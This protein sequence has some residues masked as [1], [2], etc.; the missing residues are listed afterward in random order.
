M[1]PNRPTSAEEGTICRC[2]Q[3]RL[4][5]V[6][7]P[8]EDLDKEPATGHHLTDGDRPWQSKTPDVIGRLEDLEDAFDALYD[9]QVPSFLI[10]YAFRYALGRTS[11]AVGEVV[12]YL[13]E[14]WD[15]IPIAIRRIIHDEIRRRLKQ[16]SLVEDA[17]S[18]LGHSCDR[19]R[20]LQVLD[21]PLPSP[22]PVDN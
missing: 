20:W 14:H 21:L 8:S 2:Y 7:G 4:G 17:R 9:E 3:N 6:T 11:Y 22:E 1:M 5:V 15:E 19:K 12:D 10:L 13:E 16:E 18:L